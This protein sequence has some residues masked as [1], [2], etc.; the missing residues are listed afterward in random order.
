MKSHILTHTH[1]HTHMHTYTTLTPKWIAILKTTEKTTGPTHRYLGDY[2]FDGFDR[3]NK[4]E[5][6]IDL[7]D[8]M[9]WLWLKSSL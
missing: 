3:V 6:N 2:S 1:K 5:K 4:S 8:S 7:R 9:R